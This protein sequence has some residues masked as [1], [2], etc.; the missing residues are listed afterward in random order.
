MLTAEEEAV[1]E[2][3]VQGE[4]EIPSE[5][6]A[7]IVAAAAVF[8]GKKLHVRGISELRQTEEKTSRWTSHGRVLVQTSHNLALKHPQKAH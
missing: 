5:V 4:A 2:S 1:N 8:V 6:L 3:V 7:A